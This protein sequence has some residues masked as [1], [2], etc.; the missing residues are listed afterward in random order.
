MVG[1]VRDVDAR[2]EV[3]PPPG[4]KAPLVVV[5]GALV[6]VVVVAAVVRVV[7][8]EPL[9]EPLV[10]VP[11]VVDVVALVAAVVVSP[12]VAVA[13][14]VVWVAVAGADTVSEAVALTAEKAPSRPVMAR[15]RSMVAFPLP[16]LLAVLPSVP[17]QALKV[18][19]LAMVPAVVPSVW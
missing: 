15:V 16:L 11:K 12:V 9:V 4:S 13:V 17:S 3:S 5:G 6:V 14:L 19:A 1:E 2:D 8:V 10:S 18:R 7:S